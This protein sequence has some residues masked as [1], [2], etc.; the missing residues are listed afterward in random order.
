MQK[1]KKL[2]LIEKTSH[3]FEQIKIFWNLC[4][5]KYNSSLT[6]QFETPYVY[7]CVMFRPANGVVYI[8][9]TSNN[10]SISRFKDENFSDVFLDILHNQLYLGFEIKNLNG[11]YDTNNDIGEISMSKII[12][13][14]DG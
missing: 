9:N 14:F 4:K 8:I 12:F 6:M 5:F 13:S 7:Q 2:D 3:K 1:C 11:I 10:K